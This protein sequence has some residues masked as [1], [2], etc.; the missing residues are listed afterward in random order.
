[1]SGARRTDSGRTANAAKYHMRLF[2]AGDEPNSAIAKE[3]LDRICSIYLNG[4][5]QVEIIDVLK[6]S[7]RHWRS[8]CWSRRPW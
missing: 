1:M 5:C 4:N 7:A 2:V 3:S 8:G 6:T